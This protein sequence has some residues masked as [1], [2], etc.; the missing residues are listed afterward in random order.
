[1]LLEF[2]NEDMNRRKASDGSDS[3]TAARDLVTF[4][5]E[6]CP[7]SIVR[8]FG[9]YFLSVMHHFLIFQIFFEE[10]GKQIGVYDLPPTVVKNLLSALMLKQDLWQLLWAF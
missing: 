2:I 6:S 1:M 7:A 4:F 3:S 10:C 5:E 8:Q 9:R